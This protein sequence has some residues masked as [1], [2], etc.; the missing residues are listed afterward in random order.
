MLMPSRMRLLIMPISDL[1]GLSSLQV[2]LFK[3]SGLYIYIYI[4]IYIYNYVYNVPS[5]LLP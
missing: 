5:R 4:Y 2:G 1:L 3:K